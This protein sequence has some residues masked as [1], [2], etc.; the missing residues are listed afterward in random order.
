MNN[1]NP[2]EIVPEEKN[3]DIKRKYWEIA[4]GLQDV[5][6]LK[7]SSYLGE[8][9]DSN[10]EGTLSNREIEEL[11]Y[12]HYEKETP[13]EKEARTKECDIV[14]NR[15]VELLNYDGMALSPA[16]LKSI[17]K[18]LFHD[19]YPDAGEFRKV[20]IFKKE[21]ILN[22]NTVK[23]ANYFMIEEALKYD[24]AEE[25]QQKY[26]SLPPEAVIKRIA[27]FTSS[28][29]QVHPFSEGN[30][31]TT[32]ILME[33]YLNSLGFPVDNEL[34]KENSL[35]FRNALVRSNYA[36][37]N[38]RIN[39]TNEYIHMFYENLLY[40]GKHILHS[41]DL[42]INDLFDFNQEEAGQTEG[43]SMV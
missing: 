24:F 10:I 14:S 38:K 12:T 19:I 22:G 33:R 25:M 15:I 27:E 8:L 5:D 17:H 20:N 36:D 4:I 7:P 16:S 41:R 28:V 13:E 1:D 29:W 42:I 9:A 23:Y 40:G 11:L 18:Y 37:Y 34:F 2:Y 39:S 43:Q 21:P 6:N 32:A 26:T 3:K 35:Y 30:T 31:R